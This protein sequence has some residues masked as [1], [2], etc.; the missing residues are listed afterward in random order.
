[1]KKR[2]QNRDLVESTINSC[3]DGMIIGNE[4]SLLSSIFED[5]NNESN[6][7]SSDTFENVEFGGGN[8][9]GAGAGEEW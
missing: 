6:S 3:I 9:G 7:M 2:K 4:I 8:F 5:N 1:M